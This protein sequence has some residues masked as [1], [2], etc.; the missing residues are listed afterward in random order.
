MGDKSQLLKTMEETNEKKTAHFHKRKN[1]NSNRKQGPPFKGHKSK[2][3][4]TY[5]ILGV[6]RDGHFHYGLFGTHW[7]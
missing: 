1:N 6:A 5:D 7:D 3:V 4:L 2:T